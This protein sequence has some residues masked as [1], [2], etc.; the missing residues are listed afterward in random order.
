MLDVKKTE[1]ANV[2]S[3]TGILKEL[4]IVEGESAKGAWIRGTANIQVDQDINGVAQSGIVQNKM[5][6]M[7]TKKDGTPN[8]VYDTILKYKTDFISA[9][10]ADDISEASRVTIPS[11][12]LE[13]NIWIDPKTGNERSSFQISGNFI[14]KAKDD[15]KDGATFNLSGYV[16][17]TEPEKDKEG[18]ETGRLLV[19]FGVIG[20]GGKINRLT[21]IAE[22]A[23]KAHIEQNWDE[24]ETVKVVGRINMVQK[25]EEIREKSGFG[26]DIV[27]TRTISKRELIITG[28]SA[29]SLEEELSYD[30]D[31]IK[32][33]CAERKARIEEMKK[34]NATSNG[35]SKS[36]SADYGF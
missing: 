28:G 5:F 35:S 29:G 7:R 12:K 3:I 26:E 25:T 18:E 22:G 19:T 33:A 24:E 9:A 15:E 27:K 30:K 14:N 13:E 2:V 20:F 4:D 36:K 17:R 6:S 32:A 1:S 31:S 8:K 34:A 11:A 16:F 23:A 21:L 10:A